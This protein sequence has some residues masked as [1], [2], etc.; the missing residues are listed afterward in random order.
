MNRIERLAAILLLLQENEYTSDE[1]ARHFEVSRRTVLRDVQ[2]LS[3]MG[4]P[5]IARQGPGGGYSLPEDYHTRPL[6]LTRNEAFLLLLALSRL[7]GLA[8]LPFHTEM[9]SLE[10]KLGA[11][12]P[13]DPL[14][15]ARRLLSTIST[16]ATEG[17]PPARHLEALLEAAQNENWVRVVY[18]SSRRTTTQ[19]LLPLD[20]YTQDGFWYLQAYSH[21]RQQSRTYR[22]DR[23]QSLASPAEDFHPAPFQPTLPYDHPSHPQIVARLTRRGADLVDRERHLRQQLQRLPDGSA[24]LIFRCPLDELDYFARFFASLGQDVYVLTPDGLRQRLAELGQYF[25]ETYLKR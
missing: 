24:E 2:A 5:V 9:A 22:I 6:P 17:I 19:H 16:N 14:S 13:Q 21:E 15:K 25:N 23:I 12:L 3:E 4:V 20:I 11:L 7:K 8:G 10:A 18:Q 1:I